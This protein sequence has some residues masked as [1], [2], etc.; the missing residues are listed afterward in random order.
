MASILRR[1]ARPNGGVDEAPQ[2]ATFTFSDMASQGDAYVRNVR[3]A[4]SQAVEKAN[5]EADAIRKR[6]EA[7]GHAAAEAT[8]AKRLDE[9]IG[10]E[11]RTLRPALAQVVAGL[12]AA[13]GEW[14]AHWRESAV[15]LAVAIAEKIVRRELAQDATISETW[16]TEALELAAGASDITIRLA[17]SDMEHLRSHAE[18]LAASMGGIGDARFLADP[19]IDAGGCR[20]ETRHGS[21]DQQLT[22]QLDRVFEE[23]T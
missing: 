17:P 8:I 21:I 3:T 16:L 4:A 22:T 1:G 10:Q 11:L 19:S 7:E 13:R 2:P 18:K 9:Q 15:G 12:E 23:L 6:A 20:V 14:Q 5:A